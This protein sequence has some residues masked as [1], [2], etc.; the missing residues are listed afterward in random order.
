[1]G[2]SPA[3]L[4]NHREPTFLHKMKTAIFSWRHWSDACLWLSVSEHHFNH[5]P[6]SVFFP[7]NWRSQLPLHQ[8]VL[9]RHLVAFR[10]RVRRDLTGALPPLTPRTRV[11]ADGTSAGQPTALRC[12]TPIPEVTKLRLLS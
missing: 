9:S 12:H 2:L 1:M 3:F 6:D 5:L 4:S 7:E 10:G 8:A 11:V